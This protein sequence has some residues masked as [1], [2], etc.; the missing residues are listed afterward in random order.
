LVQAT[1]LMVAHRFAGEAAALAAS[2]NLTI[3]PPP[4]PI[5]VQPMDF[6]HAEE[7]ITRAEAEARAFLAERR[8]RV[9]P[10]RRA[11]RPRR[12]PAGSALKLPPAS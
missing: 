4:C 1:S 6:G 11:R 3:L 9:V 10:L 7:L 12:A 8:G 2:A 5:D